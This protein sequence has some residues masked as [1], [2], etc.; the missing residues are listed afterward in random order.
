LVAGDR[1]FPETRFQVLVVP[2]KRGIQAD[3]SCTL[4]AF[5]VGTHDDLMTA[6]S[7]GNRA[8]GC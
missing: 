2:E 8:E 1:D 3:N 6:L 4:P 5:K 7:R